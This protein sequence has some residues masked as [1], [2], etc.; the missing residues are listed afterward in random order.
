VVNPFAFETGPMSRRLEAHRHVGREYTI[1]GR[2]VVFPAER[3]VDAPGF[4]EDV[5]ARRERWRLRV[6]RRRQSSSGASPPIEE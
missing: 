5:A 2:P 4:A 3:A 1:A 6:N